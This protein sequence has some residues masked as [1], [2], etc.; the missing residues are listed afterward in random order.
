MTNL[1]GTASFPTFRGPLM[2][3]ANFKNDFFVLGKLSDGTMGK[4]YK[5][6]FIREMIDRARKV[7]LFVVFGL[8]PV[9]GR[10][11]A[12][13]IA[14]IV[15]KTR[16]DTALWNGRFVV[17]KKLPPLPEDELLELKLLQ[18]KLH[19]LHCAS[20]LSVLSSKSKLCVAIEFSQV[21]F[22]T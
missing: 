7:S 4:T 15:W 17:Y 11:V 1:Q 10:D 3:A 18:R 14:K 19:H 21:C 12:T 20:L 8:R 6:L 22:I 9:L 2:C 5:A 16:K 13:L